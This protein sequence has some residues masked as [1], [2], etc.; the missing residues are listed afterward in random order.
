MKVKEELKRIKKDI[1]NRCVSYDDIIY[2]QKHMDDVVAT[3]DIEL[4]YW[5]EGD[6]AY[7]DARCA[8]MGIPLF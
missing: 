3:H 8:E 5:A 7:H 2:L 1:E 6:E 4:V